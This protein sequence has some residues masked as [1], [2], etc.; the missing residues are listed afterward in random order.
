MGLCYFTNQI[1]FFLFKQN[2]S[3]FLIFYYYLT[4]QIGW[5]RVCACLLWVHT[6]CEGVS[7]H[8][9]VGIVVYIYTANVQLQMVKNA[10]I[11]SF[12]H[13]LQWVSFSDTLHALV[14]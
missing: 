8:G 1:N 13:I 4:V 12:Y 14:L 6:P 2:F 10:T 7:M 3:F 9:C 11:A 5:P